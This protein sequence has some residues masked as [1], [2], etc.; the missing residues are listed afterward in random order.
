MPDGNPHLPAPG[1]P[2][3]WINEERCVCGATYEAHRSDAD[4]AEACERIRVAA[5]DREE[6]GG[7]GWRR[8]RTVLW[9]MRCMKL[10]HWFTSHYGCGHEF[11]VVEDDG[12]LVDGHGAELF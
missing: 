8:R 4:F 6:S 11:G 1:P 3:P 5:G 2:G 12:V 7:G 9:M 10:E